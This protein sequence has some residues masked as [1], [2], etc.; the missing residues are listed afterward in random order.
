M[1]PV[2]IAFVVSFLQPAKMI[3]SGDVYYSKCVLFL[4]NKI[5]VT[6]M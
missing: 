6:I 3:M 2:A 4:N 1:G 5:L